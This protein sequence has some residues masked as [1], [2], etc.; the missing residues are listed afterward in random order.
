[1]LL[2]INMKNEI[3]KIGQ[4]TYWNNNFGSILQCYATQKII[5]DLGYEPILLIR[6]EHGFG[7]ILQGISFRL[8][9]YLMFFRYPKYRNK[10]NEILNAYKENAKN[11]LL[12]E[13]YKY[14][15]EFIKQEISSK[16][17]SYQELKKIAKT[18]IYITF[19][20][21]SDQIW[22]G[23]WFVKN[24][25]W[26]LRFAPKKKRIAWAPSFGT[27]TLEEYNKKTYKKYIGEY[28]NIS[29]RESSGVDII[30]ELIGEKVP[31]IVDPTLLLESDQ[32]SK[33]LSTKLNKK[34]KY[35]CL[36][37]LDKPDQGVIDYIKRI[38][39]TTNYMVY[40]FA[41]WYKD[42]EKIKSCE[43]IVG[44]PKEFLYLIK[45]AEI[46][47]TDSFHGTVFS[48]NFKK[49]FFKFKRKYNHSSDQS[50]RLWSIL[51]MCNLESQFI[52]KLSE[53]KINLTPLD[54][55]YAT[56]ILKIERKKAI[57]FLKESIESI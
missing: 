23:S 3:K 26:F 21:G 15:N 4:V 20:S 14:M 11:G 27:D 31:Q 41:Y 2:V 50:A 30:Y 49:L 55:T 42:F 40:S 52:S 28:K 25:M 22:S 39:E 37:F 12:E 44:G 13:N 46:I 19:I 29:V 6:K 57:D 54:F 10:F 47:C 7:R 1:M 16:S 45:N 5:K 9:R 43:V 24:P 32:W 34:N 33:K 56:E 38:Q 18:N 8:N 17:Y 53:G 48:I 51:K 36:F 35:I